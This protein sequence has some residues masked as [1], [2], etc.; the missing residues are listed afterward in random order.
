MTAVRKVPSHRNIV[1]NG[2]FVGRTTVL[3]AGDRLIVEGTDN[4]KPGATV[5]PVAVKVG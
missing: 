2:F 1:I 3:R 5:K 4:A